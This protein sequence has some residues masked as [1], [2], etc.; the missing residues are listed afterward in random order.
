M[1]RGRAGTGEE[2]RKLFWEGGITKGRRG[3]KGVM[4]TGMPGGELLMKRNG[5]AGVRL[6]RGG[7]CLR[8]WG[9]GLSVKTLRLSE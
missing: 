6:Q 7:L 3:K 1:R 5:D 8:K 9:L 4:G 2:V